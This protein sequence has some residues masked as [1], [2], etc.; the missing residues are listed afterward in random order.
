MY[1]AAVGPKD[2]YDLIGGLQFCAML[3]L[4]LR[5]NHKLLDIGCGSLRGGRLFIVYLKR[6]NYHGIEPDEELV[7]AGIKHEIGKEL[8]Q[9]KTPQI[10]HNGYFL[11]PDIGYNYALA[12]SIFSHASKAQIHQCFE[13]LARY[14]VP[15]GGIFAAT[16]YPGPDSD[17]QGWSKPR[18]TYTWNTLEYIAQCNGFVGERLP[19]F[20]HPYQKWAKFTKRGQS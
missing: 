8:F 20:E 11:P 19:E 18:V 7:K 5:E 12:Q 14:M 1:R 17:L 3:K 10:V 15:S 2:K 4:G 13:N 6:G 16:W 9:K